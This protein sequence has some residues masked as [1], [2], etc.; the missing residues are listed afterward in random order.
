M[1]INAMVLVIN[2]FV[3]N[4]VQWK[5][6]LILALHQHKHTYQSCQ[7][8]EESNSLIHN[9]GSIIKLTGL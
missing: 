4:Q 5:I 7:N 3:Y 9:S 2:H 1:K 6:T 8:S